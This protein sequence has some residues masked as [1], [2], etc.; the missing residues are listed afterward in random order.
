[1]VFTERTY[2]FRFTSFDSRADALCAVH[3]RP[4]RQD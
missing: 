1:V 3:E 2:R 4:R